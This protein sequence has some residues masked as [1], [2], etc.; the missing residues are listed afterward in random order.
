MIHGLELVPSYL[1]RHEVFE[2]P[3]EIYRAAERTGPHGD[4]L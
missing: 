2:P 1:V 3:V 4:F